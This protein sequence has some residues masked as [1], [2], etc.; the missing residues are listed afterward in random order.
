MRSKAFSGTPK[1]FAR[2]CLGVCEPVGEQEGRVLVE[3]PVVEDEEE[4]APVVA[5]PLDRVRDAGREEPEVTL[6]DIVQERL[7]PPVDGGD[8]RAALQ[9]V[10]PLGLPV[11]MEL[12]DGAPLQPH[13]DAG[14][15][16]GDAELADRGL[17]GPAS[18]FE[19]HAA[20]GERPSQVGEGAGIGRR[21]HDHVRVLGLARHVPRS[22]DV[23]ALAVTDGLGCGE[24]GSPSLDEIVRHA[25]L[26]FAVG[27]VRGSPR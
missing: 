20:V 24:V 8:P 16:R 27:E 10:G 12:A 21:R 11:E 9:D 1:F 4:L 17:S 15:L 22:E 18:F 19:A 7:A 26:L 13:V 2:M 14:D 3:V 6:P 25:L 23:R 5:D